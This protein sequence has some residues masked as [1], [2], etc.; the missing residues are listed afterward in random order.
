MMLRHRE[1]EPLSAATM[2]SAILLSEIA[3]DADKSVMDQ[4]RRH[5]INATTITSTVHI[6]VTPR[7]DFMVSWGILW[8]AFFISA[9]ILTWQVFRENRILKAREAADVEH[10]GAEAVS[11]AD[12][13]RCTFRRLLLLATVSRLIAMPIMIWTHPLWLQF[14]G[15][16]LPEMIFA[17]AWTLMVTFF[18]QLVGS[19]TGTVTTTDAGIVIQATAYIVYTCLIVLELFNSVAS[20]LLYA[21]LC[22]IYA[23][24]LGAVGYVCPKLCMMLQPGLLHHRP[25]VI[26]LYLCTAVCLLVFAGHIVVFARIVIAPP[27]RVYWWINYGVL[28]LAPASTFLIIMN[29]NP[30][31]ADRASPPQHPPDEG[32]LGK[33]GTSPFS[34]PGASIKR[35]DSLGSASSNNNNNRQQ[36]GSEVVSLLKGSPSYGSTTAENS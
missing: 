3:K 15:D 18:V 7:D 35:V 26:R 16:T 20:V 32:S 36:R 13:T 9:V 12:R 2:S 8:S 28:E 1:E 34:V 4:V 25:L 14:V 22:C 5:D 27:D 31:K 10:G 29:P 30:N 17:T 21:L 33:R 11:T 24:L 6:R 19:A 23:A